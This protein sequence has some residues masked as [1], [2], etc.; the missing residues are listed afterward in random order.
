MSN[1]I[2][3][4]L[5]VARKRR[6]SGGDTETTSRVNTK[7]PYFSG[8]IHSSVSGRTDHLPMTVASGSYVLPA[9]IVSAG[10]E[11]S[12]LAGFK[13]LR[14]TFGG[15]P[16]GQSGSPY[17]QTSGV[18]GSP[19]PR[20]SGGRTKAAGIMFLSPE[21]EVLLLKRAGADHHGEWG[22][23]AGH[24]E[25]GETPEQAARRETQEEAG[26]EHDGGLSPFMH[27]V[28]DKVDF[29]TYVAHS[30][31]FRPSLNDEHDEA[32]WITPKDA[33][34]LPLHPGVRAAL[35][36]LRA[37]KSGG[38]SSSG[39]PIVAAGGEWVV[40][41]EH[42]KAVGNGDI[43]MGHRVLDAFVLRVR[44]E[45]IHTLKHLEPPRKD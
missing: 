27:Q 14:R 32:K 44:K 11:G 22:L 43:D 10:G 31:R 36:K 33:E 39:V 1:E 15:E 20:A 7:M 42:V 30:H 25:K 21:K 8:P 38:G 18:Y 41:P 19:A 13:I 6:D 24:V 40:P 35:T 29:T 34:K 28:N 3:E 26:Y 9:D 5:N 16:Y 4:A 12:T 2:Q 23:P 37:G 17:G 45:L